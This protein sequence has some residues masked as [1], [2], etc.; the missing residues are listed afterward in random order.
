MPTYKIII[1]PKKIIRKEEKKKNTNQVQKELKKITVKSIE[2]FKTY[3]INALYNKKQIKQIACSLLSNP[4][5][6]DYY[7]N[8]SPKN[9]FFDAS[10]EISFKEG[11]TNNLSKTVFE[12]IKDLLEDDFDREANIKTSKIY[13]IKSKHSVIELKNF[14]ITN[15]YNP[16]IENLNYFSKKEWKENQFFKKKSKPIFFKIKKLYQEIDIH[17]SDNKLKDLSSKRCLSL[18]LKEMKCIQNYYKQKEVEQQRK[19]KGICK[20]PT[21]VEIEA[22]AQTWSEHCKHKI[23]SAT[24]DYNEVGKKERI[25]SIYQ[26]F[27]KNPSLK[28]MKKRK[29]ILSAFSDNGGIFKFDETYGICVKAETHNAPSALEPYGGAITGILGV[30]R[31]IIGTGIGAKPIFN[32]NILCFADPNKKRKEEKKI[33]APKRMLK[34]VHRGIQDGGNQLGIPTVNGAMIFDER[35]LGRPLVFCGSGGLIPLKIKGQ[36]SEKKSIKEGDLIVMIGG[37][38]GKDGIH[39]ATF[40]SES[41]SETSPSSAVQIGDPMTQKKMMDYL[42]EARDLGLYRTLTDNGAGGLSSSVGELAILSK[43]CE[44]HL[45]KAPLKYQGLMPWEILISEAQ[46]R[47]TLVVSPKKK[48]ALKTLAKKHD[49]EISVIGHFTASNYFSVYYKHQIVCFLSMDFLHEG[50]KPLFLKAIW[51]PIETTNDFKKKIKIKNHFFFLKTILSRPNIASKE[52][53][54]RQYD[55]EVQGKNILKP[56]GGIENS[57]PMDAAVL[58]PVYDSDQGVVVANGIAPKY[59]QG[60]PYDMAQCALDEAVRNIVSVGGDPKTISGL[61]NFCWPDPVFSEKTPDGKEKLA[62]LVRCAKGLSEICLDYELPLISGKDSMKND[63]I[64]GGKKI[65]IP[66]TLLIST[67]GIIENINQVVTSDFK[68]TDSYVY[69]LGS[70]QNEMGGSECYQALQLQGGQT[71]KVNRKKNYLL[72]TKLHK[73]IKEGLIL[74]CHDLSDGGLIIALAECAFGGMRGL[75]INLDA[76]EVNLTDLEK[77]YSET[78]GRFIVEV[79]QKNKKKFLK[80]LQKTSLTLL[81]KT[82]HSKKLK[83]ISKK[84]TL[85]HAKLSTLKKNWQKALSF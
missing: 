57:A 33:I 50:L 18:S 78:Q 14:L 28:I 53:W 21:D 52:T 46:E 27:I 34:E 12:G 82:N 66:P 23:F 35:Y 43:G 39:G 77:M 42:L 40:S 68:Q 84:K 9:L 67:L 47:M 59:S 13:F 51:K 61:D 38:I 32:T 17:Q 4:I 49:V 80:Q 45:E 71:P 16:L 44:V 48:E 20:N 64:E 8:E 1:V 25:E 54:V 19:K 73:A 22:L 41:L 30:N 36:R 55:H 72:Y 85:I 69:L 83:V 15:Y 65:S 63:Y 81:G 24:I 74:A 3:E 62:K 79:S 6:E 26:T 11:V 76:L 2:I 5:L 37:R 56:F 10:F 70:T 58:K 29:D 75:C 31:D 60:D 7:I